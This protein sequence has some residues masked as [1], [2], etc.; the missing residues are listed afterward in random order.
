MINFEGREYIVDDATTNAYN[1]LNYINKYMADNNIKNR[2]GE[3]VQ[4]KINLA[5][6]IWLIIFGIGYVTSVIQKMLFAVAQAFSIS[7]CADQQVLNLA[8]IARIERKQ[9]SYSTMTMR[10]TAGDSEC[11]I[12]PEDTITVT[13]EDEKYIFKPITTYNIPAHGTD[14]VVT[15]ADK[16]GPVYIT[17]DSID[18]FDKNIANMESCTNLGSEPGTNIES[19]SALRTRIQSNETVTPVNAAVTALNGLTGVTKA[20]ILYNIST[21]ESKTVAG[22][23]VPPRNAIVFI[24]G[25]ANNLAETYFKY[26]YAPTVGGDS[27]LTQ[28]YK[29]VNNQEFTLNYFPPEV[30][31]IYVKVHVKGIEGTIATEVTDAI[32]NSIAKLSNSLKMGVNYTQS[33][34]M[35][36]IA[37]IP[38][39]SYIIGISLSSDGSNYSDYVYMNINNI[40]IIQNSEDFITFEV[41]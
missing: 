31:N 13:Y 39:Y 15:I 21:T 26:M 20:N 40:G 25:T 37:S 18:K 5:S 34:I 7:N 8:Q 29:E 27:G 3:I 14:S 17:S 23:T 28:V 10:V 22:Y 33:Y 36:S 19:I 12:T 1:L 35:E 4:F 11:I 30:K 24:Q 41:D 32:R 38:E 2:K 9:G 6:P 16:T